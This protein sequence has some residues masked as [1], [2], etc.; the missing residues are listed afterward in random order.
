MHEVKVC[1][2]ANEGRT[3]GRRV[4][5]AGDGMLATREDRSH[6]TLARGKVGMHVG[7]GEGEEKTERES[8]AAAGEKRKGIMKQTTSKKYRQREKAAREQATST[9]SQSLRRDSQQTV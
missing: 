6:G 1:Q 8:R 9:A 4:R 2:G 7:R 3:D 5:N